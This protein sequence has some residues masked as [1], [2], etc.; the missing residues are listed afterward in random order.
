MII[1]GGLMGARI[2]KR[3]M[4]EIRLNLGREEYNWLAERSKAMG[5]RSVKKGAGAI[6]DQRIFEELYLQ[7]KFGK[8]N[9]V[10]IRRLFTI[11][12]NK[13]AREEGQS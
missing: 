11:A 12:K 13:K 9:A 7:G 10:H 8:Q 1:K 4:R 2:K 5:F 3:P 6:I